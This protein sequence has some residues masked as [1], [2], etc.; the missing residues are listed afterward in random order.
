LIPPTKAMLCLILAITLSVMLSMLPRAVD[1]SESEAVARVLAA[2]P[3]DVDIRL[4][5]A[6]LLAREGNLDA[7]EKAADQ[8]LSQAPEYLDAHLLL[9]RIAGW[10][11]QFE[12]ALFHVDAVLEKAPTNKEA[13]DLKLDILKWMSDHASTL[14]LLKHLETSGNATPDI[15]VRM[16]A[17]ELTRL[18]YL[19]AYRHAKSALEL[20]PNHAP[21]KALIDEIRRVTIQV[22]ESLEYYGFKGEASRYDRWGM[23]LHAAAT[24]F[25]NAKLSATVTE[26]YIYR[27]RTINNQIGLQGDYRPKRW[28]GFT[29]SAK[30]GKPAHVIAKGA[31][32]LAMRAEMF[33]IMDIA[34]SLGID[35][36][37]W[38]KRDPAL[39]IR[40]A[41]TTGI[42]LH[43]QVRIGATYSLS[44]IKYCG[45]DSAYTHSGT[46]HVTWLGKRLTANFLAGFSEEK[47]PVTIGI[48]PPETCEEIQSLESSIAALGGHFRLINIRSVHA[49][50]T[51]S[52]R[53]NRKADIRGGYRLEQKRAET[54]PDWIPSHIS[55]LGLTTWF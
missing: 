45:N 52:F 54:N 23:G 24:A 8:V 34:L 22:T 55:H 46:G 21:A 4:K 7:A 12:K 44:V 37:P 35:I 38:P 5:Y 15:Y 16:A 25:Q 17:V 1:A 32:L 49:G 36:L 10:R 51:L 28:I 50:I 41:L 29:A 42:Y 53:L 3:D 27:F 31:F 18:Q 43:K 39:L 19:H 9:G 30:L 40:P 2:H 47:D 11:H 33:K 13:I 26:S 14:R 48:I 20:D 6:I